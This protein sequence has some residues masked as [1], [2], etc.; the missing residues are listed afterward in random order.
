[1]NNSPHEIQ[2]RHTDTAIRAQ[3]TE[4]E[5]HP[6]RGWPMFLRIL[7]RGSGMAGTA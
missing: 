5:D 7:L 2:E 6:F 1:M 4:E 3:D